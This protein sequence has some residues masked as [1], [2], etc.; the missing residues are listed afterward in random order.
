MVHAAELVIDGHADGRRD[1]WSEGSFG[2][3]RL[4]EGGS[5]D[6]TAWLMVNASGRGTEERIIRQKEWPDLQA[7]QIVQVSS[8]GVPS[9]SGI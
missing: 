8:L 4:P 2:Q 1:G 5:S 9:V 3:W 6:F 7:P